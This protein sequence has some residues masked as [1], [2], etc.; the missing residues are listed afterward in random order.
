ML[1]S[2]ASNTNDIAKVAATDAAPQNRVGAKTIITPPINRTAPKAISMGL[3]N[4][5]LLKKSGSCAINMILVAPDEEARKTKVERTAM[6]AIF[7]P[8]TRL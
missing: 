6:C 3:L 8:D 1:P 2:I 5:Y 4:P 7:T